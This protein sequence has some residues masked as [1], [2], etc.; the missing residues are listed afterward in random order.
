MWCFDKK[1]LPLDY[2][3]ALQKF[4]KY[5]I[6]EYDPFPCFFTPE[7]ESE[8]SFSPTHLDFA[9]RIAYVDENVAPEST[10]IYLGIWFLITILG[11][12]V[13]YIILASFLR[14]FTDIEQVFGFKF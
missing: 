6:D 1:N 4:Y 13:S 11:G 9:P 12:S 10:P 2:C 5:T 7:S 3:T 14:I 8:I